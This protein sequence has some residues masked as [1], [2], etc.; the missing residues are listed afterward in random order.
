M[1]NVRSLSDFNRNQSALIDELGK[2][3]EPLY[4]TRNGR[5]S[6]VVMDS[7]AFD[8]MVSFRNELRQR[9]IRVYDGIMRGFEEIRSGES[10]SADEADALIRKA[11]GWA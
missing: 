9:E 1:P 8:E 3:R 5:S 6:V 11:K 10:M 7:D 4:L 2:T